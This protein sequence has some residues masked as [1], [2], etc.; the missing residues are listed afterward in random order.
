MMTLGNFAY[1]PAVTTR[2][3]GI[4]P[5]AAGDYYQDNQ[6]G[7][8]DVLGAAQRFHIFTLNADLG[9]SEDGNVAAQS[10]NGTH[11]FG[12]SQGL[13]GIE[14]D[15][16]EINYLQTIEGI[17]S[18]A[19]DSGRSQK[20]VTG[21][22]T[23]LTSADNGHAVAIAGV[24][25]N[26]LKANEVYQDTDAAPYID[27][28]TEFDRLRAVSAL[29]ANKGKTY[30]KTNDNLL[31]ID[32]SDDSLQSVPYPLRLTKQAEDGALLPGA[33]YRLV[34]SAGKPLDSSQDDLWVND[35]NK[36][37]DPTK[38]L[39]DKQGQINV[40]VS[41]AGTYSFVETT[42]PAG[43]RVD[44]EPKKV[45]TGSIPDATYVNLSWKQLYAVGGEAASHIDFTGRDFHAA[46]AT[47]LIIDVDFTGYD[48]SQIDSG[49]AGNISLQG[50]T[51]DDLKDSSK[52]KVL[53][54]FYGYPKDATIP[55]GNDD[56]LGTILA[57]DA[58]ITVNTGGHVYGSIIAK[59]VKTGDTSHRWDLNFQ[60]TPGSNVV[61]T[62][63][64][65]PTTSLT[66]QKKWKSL[67]DAD[68]A[69]EAGFQLYQHQDGHEGKA[70]GDVVTLTGK[71]QDPASWKHTIGD[72]PM[73]DAVG[74]KL[75]YTVQETG[76]KVAD[77]AADTY[78][79]S[80]DGT[81]VTNTQYGLV[82]KKVDADSGQELTDG[83]TFTV[84]GP[85][86]FEKTIK[87][88]AT[89]PLAPGTY[90]ITET[91]PP[92]GYQLDPTPQTVTLTKDG[93]WLTGAGKA[94]GTTAPTEDGKPVDGLYVDASDQYRGQLLHVV[95]TDHKYLSLKI[96]KHDKATHTAL[97]GAVFT[98]TPTTGAPK[99]LTTGDDGTAVDEQLQST[100]NQQYTLEET[101]PP[102]G[103]D[104]LT[105][106]ATIQGDA[107]SLNGDFKGNVD[108]STQGNQITLT[109]T[110]TPRGRLPATGGTGPLQAVLLSGLAALIAVLLFAWSWVQKRREEA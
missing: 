9:A 57:P 64:K 84:T 98:L 89:A 4:A 11:D 44:S 3:D 99:T 46:D 62:D 7:R 12:T 90:Q 27:F 105:G 103:Y 74:H 76:A 14:P 22:T 71:L 77:H 70:Y 32:L 73:E 83:V 102:G 54:N 108:I 40:S 106:S 34:D 19:L 23:S 47:P 2:G 66:I 33:V 96:I 68:A 63:T 92:T 87:P 24:K 81:T 35:A 31:S 101:T 110:D 59:S 61:A 17:Q 100:A 37:S 56:F 50:L 79:Q 104:A 1:L 29:F 78:Q 55:I 58:N 69:G 16:E 15:G 43:Y 67:T 41:K 26:T 94:L 39:T 52:A 107:V 91:T 75:T 95:K 36:T 20:F 82:V 21:P 80:T 28:K 10:F 85:A 49:R 18:A 88:G 13:K 86:G 60:S 5:Q 72:L 45:E 48:P 53:W 65:I 8:D 6:A 25:N 30:Q 38:F 109:V 51:G 93:K 97:K 42:A